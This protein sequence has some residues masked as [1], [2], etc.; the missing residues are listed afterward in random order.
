MNLIDENKIKANTRYY[1]EEDTEV[2]FP[3]GGIG[4]G[5][6]SLGSRGELR[7]WEIFNGPNKN[8]PYPYSFFSLFSQFAGQKPD[9]RIL[10]AKLQ[11]PFYRPAG[12]PS[13]EMAGVP[14]FE[15]I[16][17]CGRGPFF[18]AELTDDVLPLCVRLTAFSPMIPTD[19]D[20]S[21][22]P[23]ASFCYTVTNNSDRPCEISVCATLSN[24]TSHNGTDL[25]GNLII[26]D[27]LKNEFFDDGALRGIK[28]SSDAPADSRRFGTMCLAT[29]AERFTVKPEWLAGG[30]WDGAHDFF[31][32]FGK[33][34]KLSF[35]SAPATAGEGRLE[36]VGK[37]KTGSLA[38]D[39]TLAP[40]ESHTFEF[41]LSWNFPNRPRS[42]EGH[43]C[44]ARDF[45]GETVKNYYSYT[46]PDAYAAAKR[47]AED[48]TLYIA[49]KQF[50]DALFS[51]DLDRAVIDAINGTLTVLRSTTCFRI[52]EEG[53]FLCWEGCFDHRGSCEGNCTH[54]WNYAQALAFLFPRLEQNMR[55]TEFLLETGEDGNMAFRSMQV[56]GDEKWDMLPATDGQLGCVVRL[57]RDWKFSGN[58]GLLKECYPKMKK[59]LDFAFSYWDENGD[60]VLDSRQHNT[61]DI[62]F[63]GES[64]LTNSIFFAA[65][66]AGVAMA[67]YLGDGESAMRWQAAFEKGSELMDEKLFRGGYYVQVIDDVDRYKYQYGEGCLSDQIFGQTLAHLNGLGYVLPAGHVHTAVKRIYDTNFKKDFADFVNVQRVY[68]INNESGLLVC[69]WPEGTKRPRIPFIYAD[70]VWT[71]IEY[72]VATCL[73]YEGYVREALDIVRAV[74]DRYN[75]KNRN[76]FNEVE[77][78]NHYARSLASYGLLLAF[79]GFRFDMT[80]KEISFRAQ[81]KPY[82]TFFTT[83]DCFGLCKIEGN[84]CET[85]VLYGNLNGIQIKIY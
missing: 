21:G 11:P 36:Y 78:G 74:R 23:A 82:T 3:L 12:Y 58:D 57:Y 84:S 77:C 40:G 61:Y 73:V 81:E 30:W 17:T 72:Q 38:C 34:G 70:E 79:S 19:E 69:S 7:D 27:E 31:N 29:T 50:A 13:F 63:Y 22:I 54:V 60:C 2:R 48:K 45:D 16:R 56:F 62:E 52:G 4:T 32:E 15:H 85:Q 8:T 43:I 47:L 9:V 71:G 25:F 5:S 41:I 20:R 18:E 14:R 83:A 66:K 26:E 67:R 49:S 39:T 33:T 44:P 64:S 6:V 24:L 68:A 10:E 65:L 76:P 35:V 75:G 53:T 46:Y 1:T 42:W 59:A 28:Y 51:S 80:K 37:L 55:R